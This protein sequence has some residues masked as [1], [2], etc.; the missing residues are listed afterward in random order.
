MPPGAIVLPIE[1]RNGWLVASG[2]KVD[3]R[4]VKLVVDTGAS[5]VILVDKLPR[6]GEVREDT[7]DGTASAITLYHGDG[8]IAFAGDVARHVPVDRTDSFSTLE[9]LIANLG[10][11]VAGLLG[12]T[13]LGRDRIILTR[14]S[15]VVV[16]PPLVPSPL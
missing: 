4:D 7:V 15:L 6:A 1:Y 8:E 13:S 2:I 11:D 14:E 16:L 9:G 3:G 5:N 10:G 12:L